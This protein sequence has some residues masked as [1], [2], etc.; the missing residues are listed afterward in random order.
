[1]SIQEDVILVEVVGLST[2][3]TSG[4]AFVLV[5]GEVGGTRKLP[6]VVG[7]S[8]ATA[9][10][11][12]IENKHPPRPMPHD[13]M[14]DLM[15]YANME[16]HDVLIDEIDEG[17]FFAKIRFVRNGEHAMIDSRP[18]DAVAIAV[19]LDVDIFVAE[20]V[21]EQA[22]I[23]T[24]EGDLTTFEEPEESESPLEKLENQLSRAIEDENYEEAARI[25]DEIADLKN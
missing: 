24:V 10:V 13:L 21:L 14:C 25:R 16:V 15:G 20:S 2:T 1:M 17:T 23:P 5:L 11:I 7:E 12:G 18:S 4:G 8:E 6:V 9:I 3:S 19:R 22:G